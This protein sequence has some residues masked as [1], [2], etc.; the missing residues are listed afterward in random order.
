MTNIRIRINLT[1][2]IVGRRI[3]NSFQL[4]IRFFNN[5][6]IQYILRKNIVKINIFNKMYSKKLYRF[7]NI[8]E[9]LILKQNF[10]F[11]KHTVFKVNKPFNANK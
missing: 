11:K 8:Q 7:L 3:F 1:D 10:V 5:V 6:L 4:T 9:K 2:V